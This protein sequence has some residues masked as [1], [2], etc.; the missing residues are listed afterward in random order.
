[1]AD[2][3]AMVRLV[4]FGFHRGSS[5]YLTWSIDLADIIH[6]ALSSSSISITTPPTTALP[7][8]QCQ[9]LTHDGFK[10]GY[11]ESSHIYDIDD[12]DRLLVTGM[13]VTRIYFA[14][15]FF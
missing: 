7:T 12:D 8:T 14:R 6:S 4:L 2:Y 15:Q 5:N 10:G 13:Y 9:W 1:V 3:T 11:S